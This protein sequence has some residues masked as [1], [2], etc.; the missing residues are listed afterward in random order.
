MVLL[1]GARFAP[2]AEPFA[3]LL[4]GIVCLTLWYVIGLYIMSSLHSP[5]RTTVIQ[6]L[7]LIVALPL[8]WVA[9]HQWGFNGA[10]AVST[11]VYA[12]VFFAGVWSLLRSPYVTW[13]QLIPG[14]ADVRR[15]LAL[16]RQGVAKLRT[17]GALTG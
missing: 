12:A 11:L 4:P 7:G 6:G 2:A 14:R 17:R 9:I 8:Y 10:A 3:I 5:G 13:R 15:V 1:F 16:G